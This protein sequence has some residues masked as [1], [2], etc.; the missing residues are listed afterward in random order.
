MFSLICT[1]NGSESLSRSNS[2]TSISISPVGMFGL[3]FSCWRAVTFPLIAITYSLRRR[4]A[5]WCT[6]AISGLN[7]ICIIPVTSRRSMKIRPPRS[8]RRCTQPIRVT[9]SFTFFL[10]SF[11][12]KCVL[13]LFPIKSSIFI[14]LF[15][16]L[17][18]RHLIIMLFCQWFGYH[19]PL[20]KPVLIEAKVLK[21]T[22][23]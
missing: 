2:S 9:F 15:N 19:Y 21:I 6:A 16:L 20:T 3:I 17:K 1:G 7:M 11:P 13:L 5:F 18:M 8:R 14:Y 23:T 12:A 22:L 4:P 10:F